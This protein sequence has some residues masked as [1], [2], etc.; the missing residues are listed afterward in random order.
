MSSGSVDKIFNKG[1]PNSSF[2][3]FGISLSTSCI[4]HYKLSCFLLSSRVFLSSS[5]G[6]VVRVKV[7]VFVLGKLKLFCIGGGVVWNCL[8][9]GGDALNTDGYGSWKGDGGGGGGSNMLLLLLLELKN[10]GLFFNA[11]SL[12]CQPCLELSLS[13]CS[14]HLFFWGQYLLAAIHLLDFAH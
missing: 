4:C 12:L 5:N 3:G 13:K 11:L 8:N 1:S 9:V 10:L 6:V 7:V 2:G 14:L